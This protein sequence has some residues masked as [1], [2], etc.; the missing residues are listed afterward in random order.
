[1]EA[2]TKKVARLFL[3]PRGSYYI[4]DDSG[5]AAE[6]AFKTLKLARQEMKKI[7]FTHYTKPGCDKLNKA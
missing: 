2:R 7:G 3:S 4:N 5:L 1:M 6:S